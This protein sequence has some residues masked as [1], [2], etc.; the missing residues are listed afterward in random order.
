MWTN[1]GFCYSDEVEPDVTDGEP[2]PPKMPRLSGPDVTPGEAYQSGSY[3]GGHYNRGAFS[4][5]F[6]GG[7]GGFRGSDG[8]YRGGSG[9]YRGGSGG[10]R[11]GSGGYRGGYGGYRGGTYQG[12]SFRYGSSP[13]RPNRYS[14]PHD[15][16]PGFYGNELVLVLLILSVLHGMLNSLFL[17]LFKGDL[18]TLQWESRSDRAFQEADLEEE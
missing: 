3:M 8:G 14:S 12:S 16:G 10:Y 9:G 7:S 2:R 15:G 18:K 17:L 4:G 13:I 6:R 1:R 5:G 11:G